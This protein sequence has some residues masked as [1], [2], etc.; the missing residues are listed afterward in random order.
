MNSFEE[1]MDR[2]MKAVYSVIGEPIPIDIQYKYIVQI[3]DFEYLE[4]IS[5]YSKITQTYLESNAWGKEIKIKK[6]LTGTDNQP[7]YHLV[8]KQ[9]MS[10]G[11]NLRSSKIIT[12]EEARELLAR[13]DI[14][15][16]EKF[17]SRSL[18]KERYFFVYEG[19][20]FNI[21]IYPFG[22]DKGVLEVHL[23]DELDEVK[24]PDFLEIV[25]DVTADENYRNINLTI[26]KNM[27]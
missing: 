7:C 26:N 22:N 9:F 12:E 13:Y 15:F 19:Q 1:K 20:Y 8:T 6:V 3:K 24:L 18:T 21:D 14:T 5:S 25:K 27:L 2:V 17:L 16:D 23:T 11:K 4:S 10:K